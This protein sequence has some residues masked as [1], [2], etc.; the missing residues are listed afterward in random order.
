MKKEITT[1]CIYVALV[2]FIAF[3]ITGFLSSCNRGLKKEIESLRHELAVAQQH[4]PLQ[5]DTIRDSIEVITQKV[6][7]VQKIKEVLSDDDRKMIKDL[8]ITYRALESMQKI[9]MSTSD[10]VPLTPRDSSENAP[11]EFHDAWT[12]FVYQDSMLDYTIRDKLLIT[13]D[14][15]FKKRF[16]FLKWGTKG[17]KVKT[18]HYNPKCRI[19][20]NT[21]VKKGK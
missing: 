7:E 5:R 18:V 13:V 20:Y 11:L 15:E 9:G 8:G 21:Y 10:T 3:L 4:V 2:A 19:E 6:I 16:L 12:D 17:Y 1:A 14:K